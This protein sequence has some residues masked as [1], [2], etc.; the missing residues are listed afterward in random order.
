MVRETRLSM[1]L[2]PVQNC[3]AQESAGV[4]QYIFLVVKKTTVDR[5]WR[6]WVLILLF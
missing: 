4:D 5:L 6:I 1:H 2:P 3:A